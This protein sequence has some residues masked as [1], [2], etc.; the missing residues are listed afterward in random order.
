MRRSISEGLNSFVDS[1]LKKLD[2]SYE[3]SIFECLDDIDN[4]EEDYDYEGHKVVDD[5]GHKKIIAPDGTETTADNDTEA[6][7]DI[8]AANKKLPEEDDIQLDES[9]LTEASLYDKL[10]AAGVY[11]N[12]EESLTEASKDPN[13]EIVDGQ[14][15]VKFD[16]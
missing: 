4:I 2:E 7:A 16:F 1:Q 9:T 6:K 14:E 5:N 13:T 10:V 12:V 11:D 3:K 8:D 15:F